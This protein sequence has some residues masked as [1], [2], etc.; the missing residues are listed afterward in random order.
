MHQKTVDNAA[1]LAQLAEQF[2][3]MPPVAALQLRVEGF[4]GGCLRLHA[5]LAAK[6]TTRAVPSAA[7][8]CQ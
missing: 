8:W 2:R 6:S 7:A 4:D 5:P 3:S 1:A